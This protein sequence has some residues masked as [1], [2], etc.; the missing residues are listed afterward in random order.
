MKPYIPQDMCFSALLTIQHVKY[1]RNKGGNK[2]GKRLNLFLVGHC[3]CNAHFA[4]E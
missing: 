1:E 4:A 3:H 2:I